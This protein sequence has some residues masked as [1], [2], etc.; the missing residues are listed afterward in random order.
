VERAGDTVDLS[1]AGGRLAPESARTGAGARSWL[2]FDVAVLAVAALHAV[3]FA[4]VVLSALFR[5]RM[6]VP[7]LWLGHAAMITETFRDPLSPNQPHFGWHLAGRAVGVA[8]PGDDPRIAAAIVSIVAA[9]G[10]GAALFWVFRHADDGTELLSPWAAAGVSVSIALMES[11]AAL[12]GWEALLNPG[13]RFVPLYYWFVPTAPAAMGL[14]VVLVWMCAQLARGR[15]TVRSRTLLPLIVVATAIIKPTL[16]PALALVAPA[17]IVLVRRTSLGSVGAVRGSVADAIRLVTVP[18]V[19]I[20]ILQS[21]IA[22]WFS[23]ADRRG[24]VELRPLWELGEMGGF[25]W[26]FWLVLLVPAVALVLL[27]RRLLDDDAVLLCL[28]LFAVGLVATLLF[29]RSGPTI[30][31]G[32]NGGD[33]LQLAAAGA[34][35]LVI[36]SIRRVV[37]LARG[38]S[39]SRGVSVVL[40]LALVPYLVAG[41]LTYRCQSGLAAC[42]PAELAPSW[43]QPAAD[44]RTGD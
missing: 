26:Q 32:A 25:G 17:C 8:L 15:L 44:E 36:F 38:G 40:A 9:A 1:T 34:T 22:M 3:V 24:G 13:T 4:P 12:Q 43:P 23:P 14:N 10:L 6:V 42:Y 31:K 7:N 29:A 28:G 2:P 41:V 30:Y 5:P 18:A 20:L 19:L 33:I 37:V 35:V 39:L 11:P 27:R 16:V 21:T